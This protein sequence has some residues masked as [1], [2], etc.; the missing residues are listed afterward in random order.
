MASAVA[1]AAPS[2]SSQPPL[3]PAFAG[4]PPQYRHAVFRRA[5][6]HSQHRY[7]LFKI[8]HV[9]MRRAEGRD[10]HLFNY[11]DLRTALGMS[12]R[13]SPDDGDAL[14][15]AL[16]A[17]AAL[18]ASFAADTCSLDWPAIDDDDAHQPHAFELQP[19]ADGTVHTVYYQRREASRAAVS[20]GACGVVLLLSY[21]ARHPELW[22]ANVGETAWRLRTAAERLAASAGLP[23]EVL[24]PLD[25]AVL[26][27]PAALA[28]TLLARS[29]RAEL[30]WARSSGACV[31][32]TREGLFEQVDVFFAEAALAIFLVP[33]IRVGGSSSSDDARAPLVSRVWCVIDL[34]ADSHDAMMAALVNELLRS[35]VGSALRVS[36]AATNTK[37]RGPRQCG[38]SLE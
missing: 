28:R 34:P 7:K 35:L 17:D 9:C 24:L 22:T 13:A 18:G 32:E 31:I 5:T 8:R 30:S 38:R 4:A 36:P 6:Q 26:R 11:R 23:T 20:L 10:M 3:L 29:I 37:R 25:E 21:V 14:Y 19:Q 12:Y 33:R 16:R 1:P 2:P 15:T 27:E